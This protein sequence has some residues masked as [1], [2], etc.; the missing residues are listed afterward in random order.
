MLLNGLAHY[1]F[2]HSD[3]KSNSYVKMGIILSA[4][5]ESGVRH[6]YNLDTWGRQSSLIGNVC[7]TNFVKESLNPDWNEE[8]TL[9]VLYMYQ[10]T[11]D[12]CFNVVC[13]LHD[14]A[15]L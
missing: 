13:C 4:D 10:C 8:I 5:I 6:H 1:L 12:S 2:L 14:I 11:N 3:G 9:Y 15:K 7:R